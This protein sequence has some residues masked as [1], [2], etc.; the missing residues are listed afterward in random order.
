MCIAV[1][2]W[3]AGLPFLLRLRVLA[4]CAV[5]P[6]FVR[7]AAPETKDYTAEPLPA[8]TTPSDTMG[9]AAQKF[10]AGA[11]I[12]GQWWTLFHSESLNKLV[13]Q[14]LKGN[15]DLQAAQAS[16]RQAQENYYASEGALFPSID[17]NAG[18][19]RQR[20]SSATTGGLRQFPLH[21]L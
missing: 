6:D 10:V 2:I 9:G 4:G 17:A 19:T 7:P 14:A 20:L 3:R 1:S 21:A 13:E 12:P 11:D 15:P 16:L 8:E 5:G 18:V